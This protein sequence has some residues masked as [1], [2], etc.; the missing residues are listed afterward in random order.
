MIGLPMNYV[1]PWDDEWKQIWVRFADGTRAWW[2]WASIKKIHRS[3][4]AAASAGPSFHLDLP[5]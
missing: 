1:A 2:P 3:A 5:R 4:P